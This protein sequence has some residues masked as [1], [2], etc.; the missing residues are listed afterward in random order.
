ML[1]KKLSE[2]ATLQTGLVLNR[3]EA[4]CDEETVK[5]YKKVSM[6][7]L[8]E[9]G[10]LE[11][12][13]LNIFASTEK[14]DPSLLTHANDILVKLFTP[15]FPT[16]VTEETEGMVIPSQLAVIRVFDERVL[17]EYLRYYLST[18]E[19]SELMLSIEGWRSQRTIKVGTFAEIEIPIPPIEKQRIIANLAKTDLTRRRLYTELIEEQ[20]KLTTL[21]IQKYIG[22]K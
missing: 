21:E 20:S 3:K 5:Y 4:R 19:V 14:L 6:R 8:N 16:L 13:D 9:Y 18:P 10:V 2:I 11:R 17:P 15:V 1:K 12:D 7:F 22:G